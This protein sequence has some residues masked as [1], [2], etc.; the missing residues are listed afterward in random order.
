MVVEVVLGILGDQ[1][2]GFADLAFDVEVEKLLET[3]AQSG[4]D[5]GRRLGFKRIVR[6]REGKSG[7]QGQ[8]SEAMHRY[9]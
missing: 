9:L 1:V 8:Q 2:F 6:L 4:I 5:I 3:G 7:T